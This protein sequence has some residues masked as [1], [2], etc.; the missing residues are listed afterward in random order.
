MEAD[1]VETKSQE[2][3]K[4]NRMLQAKLLLGVRLD[5]A[6]FSLQVMWNTGTEQ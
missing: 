5:G 1:F 2:D 6:H 3:N 4:R